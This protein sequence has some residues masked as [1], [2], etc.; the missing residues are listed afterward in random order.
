MK[1][2][3]GIA[4][5][6]LEQLSPEQQARLETV[7]NQPSS[8]TPKVKPSDTIPTSLEELQDAVERGV[9]QKR[10]G[11]YSSFSTRRAP[12]YRAV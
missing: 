2:L 11:Y 5:R 7:L 6:N 12:K 1:K 4:M 9:M 8:R 3:V 10:I